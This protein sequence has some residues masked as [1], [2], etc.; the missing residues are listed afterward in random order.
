[1]FNRELLVNLRTKANLTQRQLAEASSVPH[2]T[3][4]GI[5]S[6]HVVEP[7]AR[8]MKRLASVLNVDWS[9]FFEND[10]CHN[11]QTKQKAI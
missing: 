9:L 8:T 4:C 10:D 1:M 2:G 5:E 3:I 11:N 6:G 7:T